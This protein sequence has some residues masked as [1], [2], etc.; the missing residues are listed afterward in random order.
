MRRYA[1]GYILTLNYFPLQPSSLAAVI[2]LADESFANT[3]QQKAPC[4]LRLFFYFLFIYL[5]PIISKSIKQLSTLTAC[6][7]LKKMSNDKLV[8]VRQGRDAWI[9]ESAAPRECFTRG[10]SWRTSLASRTHFEGLGLEAS[11]PRKLP[12]PRLE[13]STI[14]EPL[15]FCWKT[16]QT[17]GKMCKDLFLV[18]S[19]RDRLKKIFENF[20]CLKKILKTL[21]LRLPEKNF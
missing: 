20:F 21:F 16:A 19:S 6:C 18:S 9:F 2:A 5:P 10:E 3:T 4:L 17:L 7:S 8:A 1:V 14:F 13:D 15:K 11:S 12:S